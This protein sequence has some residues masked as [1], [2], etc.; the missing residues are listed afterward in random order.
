[1]PQTDVNQLLEP[2]RILRD[3]FDSVCDTVETLVTKPEECQ[4][5]LKPYGEYSL[6]DQNTVQ[7]ILSTLPQKNASALIAA[8]IGLAEFAPPNFTEDMDGPVTD[9]KEEL[10]RLQP[11]RHNL[12]VALEGLP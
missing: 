12:H 11:I 4:K 8:I 7:D 2:A 1:M 9:I 6:S 10:Q 3:C 5:R